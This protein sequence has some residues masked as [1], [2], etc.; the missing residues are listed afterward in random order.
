MV[1]LTTVYETK[2]VDSLRAS[3][4]CDAKVQVYACRKEWTLVPIKL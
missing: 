3:H 2:M 1:G 4:S